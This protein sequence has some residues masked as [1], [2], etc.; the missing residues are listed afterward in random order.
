MKGWCRLIASAAESPTRIS[1]I[2]ARGKGPAPCRSTSASNDWSWRTRCS[3]SI[4]GATRKP[5]RCFTARARALGAAAPIQSGRRPGLTGGGRSR[6]PFEALFE[7]RCTPGI[8]PAEH[9]ELGRPIALPQPDLDPPTRQIVDD[10]QILREPQRMAVQRRQCDGLTDPAV[11]CGDG[12]GGAG[13]DGRRTIAVRLAVMLA[14][15]HRVEAQPARFAGQFEPFAIGLVVGLARL[16][17]RLEG[18][19]DAELRRLVHLNAWRM[20]PQ[21]SI[22]FSWPGTIWIVNWV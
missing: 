14:R 17:M 19:G 7:G 1:R 13:D 20:R 6:P 15:P 10:R 3:S 16:A 21:S 2:N 9:V 11:G 4:S 8:V 12:E 18:E 5:A 22:A